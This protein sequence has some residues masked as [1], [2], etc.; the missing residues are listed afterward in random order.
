V[1]GQ[2]SRQHPAV[3]R[4]IKWHGTVALQGHVIARQ[5]EIDCFFVDLDGR[6]A[7][8]HGHRV[9]GRERRDAAQRRGHGNRA[10]PRAT[11]HS[12]PRLF[13]VRRTDHSR[14]SPARCRHPRQTLST[15]TRTVKQ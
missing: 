6:P 5:A 7:A 8:S 11:R 4:I 13:Q 10:N 12:K 14:S 3:A 9:L 15:Q 1:Q 2:D